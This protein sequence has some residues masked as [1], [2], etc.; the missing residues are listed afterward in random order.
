MATVATQIIRRSVIDRLVSR[1]KQRLLARRGPMT[2]PFELEY[3]HVFVLP[4]SFGWGFGMMLIFMAL[5]G[6]NFNNNM[7]LMLVFLLGTI[8]QLT[9]F[10]AYR[11]LS[12]L[13][14]E[15]VYSQPVFCGDTAH[16][17]VFISNGDE[18]Q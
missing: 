12:G 4:T 1:L 15:S 3:R 11:N 10:I 6:L 2:P 8:A 9:T 13:R 14:I 17:H 18:R 5:G 16:F 7:A